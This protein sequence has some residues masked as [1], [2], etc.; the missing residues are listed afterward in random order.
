MITVI[1]LTYNRENLVGR[2]IESILSQTFS[3]FEFIIVDNGSSDNS[4]KIADEYAMKD[5]R[6]RVIHRERGNISCGRNTGLDSAKGDYITFI[7]DDDWAEVDFLQFLYDLI[8]ENNADISICGTPGMEYDEKYI[9]EPEDALVALMGRKYYNTAF[10]TK[11]FKREMFDNTRFPE[12]SR[13]DDIALMYKML[14]KASVVVYHGIP[15]YTFYRH[16]NNHSAWTTNHNLLNAEI[17]DTYLIV[18]RERTE[19]L[20][21]V[22]PHKADIFQ[23]YEWSFMIS[24]VEKISRLELKSCYEQRDSLVEKLKLRAN[25]LLKSE[26]IQDFE[27]EWIYCYVLNN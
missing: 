27:R 15:K 22:F 25:E 23:Y 6:I 3:D 8:T 7:D 10:P 19:W 9:M 11:L 18:Y 26:L 12:N 13:F 21:K 2:A 14:V 17:L 20:S 1:M 24:M 4:G 16:D 5:S